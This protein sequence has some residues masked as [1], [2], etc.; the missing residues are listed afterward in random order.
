MSAAAFADSAAVK[1]CC[2]AIYASDWARLFLG[3]SFH[4]GG[5]ALTE[6]LGDRLGLAPGR[7][8]LDVASGA[9][10]S[11]L[12]LARRFG[13]EVVGVDYSP[14]SVARARRAAEDAGL[15]DRVHFEV[16]D[17]EALTFADDSF[18]AVICE[19]AFCTFP[20]K[21]AAIGEMARVLR[22]GGRLGL[23]DLTRSGALPTELHSLLAWIACVADALP[24]EGYLGH[25]TAAGLAVEAN[26]PHPEALAA[27]IV[28]VRERLR[29]VELLVRLG[30]LDLPGASLGRAELVARWAAEAV[31]TGA[32]G[33]TLIWGTRPAGRAGGAAS[34]GPRYARDRRNS[35]L[36]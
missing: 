10:T 24:V 6:R 23:G 4:P 11:A 22:P 3:A 26:E 31:G 30:Q 9:G 33:Y 8:V 14:G 35:A 16:G 29:T 21:R 18:D 28:A 36:G 12:H 15:A 25:L 7:R 13:C 20:D 32:V 27:L 2:A 1:S 19:C 34:H 17:A 5:L